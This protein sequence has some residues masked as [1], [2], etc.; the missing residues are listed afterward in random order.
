MRLRL[1]CVGLVY[2]PPIYY[3]EF[4]YYPDSANNNLYKHTELPEYLSDDFDD[5]IETCGNTF[6]ETVDMLLDNE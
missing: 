6:L 1:A 5:I 3:N 2:P 4:L